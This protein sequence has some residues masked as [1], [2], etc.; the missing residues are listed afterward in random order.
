MGPLFTRD[1]FYEIQSLECAT[2]HVC[3]GVGISPWQHSQFELM[4]SFLDNRCLSV[5]FLWCM[6][7]SAFIIKL[8]FP[9]SLP[10]VSGQMGPFWMVERALENN[11]GISHQL[12][13]ET[14]RTINNCWSLLH[15]EITLFFFFKKIESFQILMSKWKWIMLKA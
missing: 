4:F 3:Q 5:I 11:K 6:H 13:V 12:R 10:I 7:I 14:S 8:S 2:K 9:I 1:H 15:G